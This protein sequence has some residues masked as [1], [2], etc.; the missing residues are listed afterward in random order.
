MGLHVLGKATESPSNS[1]L[2]VLWR[3]EC[4]GG[5]ACKLKLLMTETP[6]YPQDLVLRHYGTAG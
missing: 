1:L 5:N 6:Q 4:A 3:T 2:A